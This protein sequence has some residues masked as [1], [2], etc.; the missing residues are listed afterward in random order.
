MAELTREEAVSRYRM[1][2]DLLE[3]EEYE[4]LADDAGEE[5]VQDELADLRSWARKQDLHF[6]WQND[7]W[8]LVPADE[9]TKATW[10]NRRWIL[11]EVGLV[12][13]FMWQDDHEEG[14]G[15]YATADSATILGALPHAENE[16]RTWLVR[17]DGTANS[18]FGYSY[19][20]YRYLTVSG[21]E[22]KPHIAEA[23]DAQVKQM[24]ESE[25]DNG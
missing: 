14:R 6:V 16:P 19:P 13:T 7:E 23:T 20:T 24:T 17:V 25:A 10:K 2:Q 15:D 12:A 3:T 22:E 9:D 1:L 5:D 11:R 18:G 4:K 8:R 21:T